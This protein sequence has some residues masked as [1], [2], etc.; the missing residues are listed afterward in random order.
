M[1]HLAL[2]VQTPEVPCLIPVALLEGTFAEKLAKSAVLGY[3]GVELIS[4][5]P[6]QLDQQALKEQIAARGLKVSAVASGGMAFAT[7]LTLL[8]QDV[9]NSVL[10]RQRLKELVDFASFLGAKIVTIGSFRG[11]SSGN[12]EQSLHKLADILQETAIHAQDRGVRLAL[13]PLNR[14]ESDLINT[15]AEGLD[16]I[17]QVN[18]PALGLLVDS[19]HVNIEESSWSTPYLAALKAKRLYYA[20]I[21]D[22]NR[23]PPG[24]GLIDFRA[25]LSTLY[26]NGYE[27][28]LSAELLPLP[29]P[30]QAAALTIQYIQPILNGLAN[31]V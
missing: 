5:A 16:F 23:H 20:H 25:I 24:Q 22:N 21:G 28:W 10:A 8:N 11:R 2:T 17:Q 30:D 18:H 6:T 9:E 27:G 13:E 12:K 19:F 15:V 31:Q 3:E 4:V 26:S 29:D 1:I 14:F 7:G